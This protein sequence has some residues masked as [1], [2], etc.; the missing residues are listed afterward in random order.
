MGYTILDNNLVLYVKDTGIGISPENYESIFEH[1][2]QEEKETP[3]KYGGLGLGLSI[4]KENARLLGGAVTL[5]S[6]KGRGST[7][8]LTIPYKP[9]QL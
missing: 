5:E 3:N 7:F 9:S 2:S 1:F 8:Y 4:S 6:T